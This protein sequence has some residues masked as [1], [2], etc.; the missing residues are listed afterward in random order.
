MMGVV[1]RKTGRR[2]AQKLEGHY[3][4]CGD[5]CLVFPDELD[6]RRSGA[7]VRG[8]GEPERSDQESTPTHE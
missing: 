4:L 8:H 1:C 5:E 7:P 3:C 2:I 6:T